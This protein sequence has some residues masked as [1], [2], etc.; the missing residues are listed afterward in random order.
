MEIILAK[1][2]KKELKKL[3]DK[4]KDIKQALVDAEK[5]EATDKGV[6]HWL[7]S[8]KEVAYDA[9][10]VIGD[11]AYEALYGKIKTENQLKNKMLKF[12]SCS[13]PYV[14]CLKMAPRIQVINADFDHVHKRMKKFNLI[15][16]L[17]VDGRVVAPSSGNERETS[18]SIDYSRIVG[19][20]DDKSKLV[21]MMTDSTG[22]QE[23]LCHSHSWYGR[24]Q[25]DNT[26]QVSVQQ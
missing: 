5:Q 2:V 16:N 12:C 22:E 25:Q 18:S 11:F 9:Q 14:F 3:E 19:R 17:V 10:D 23:T 8:L 21:A 13:N 26:H 6:H 7:T 4:L 20:E 24:T 1:D 15:R